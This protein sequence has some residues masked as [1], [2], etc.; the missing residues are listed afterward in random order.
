[1]TPKHGINKI[2][3]DIARNWLKLSRGN[4]PVSRRNV[5]LLSG[6]MKRGEWVLNGETIIFS[7]DMT[8]IDG[9]HRLLALSSLENIEIESYVVVGVSKSVFDT[10]DQGKS[11]NSADALSIR[12]EKD[13]INLSAA[14]RLV[15]ILTSDK[16]NFS[17]AYS[18]KQIE[19]ALE[20]HNRIRSFVCVG[21]SLDKVCDRSVAIAISYLADAEHGKNSWEFFERL[22]DGAGLRKGSPVTALR[23]RLIQNKGSVSKLPKPYVVAIFIKALKMHMQGKTCGTL[24]FLDSEEFPRMKG[25][26]CAA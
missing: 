3:P 5:E 26:S 24:K 13:A 6:I 23:D 22:A 15:L 1:M 8:L 21:R 9:H 11:R 16:I 18:T 7:H 10:I 25:K 19:D 2:T 14:L 4:R 20:K 12:G 17:A